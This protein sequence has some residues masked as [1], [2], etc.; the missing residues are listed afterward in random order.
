MQLAV[1]GFVAIYAP[2]LLV[3]GVDTV[4]EEEVT[5]TTLGGQDVMVTGGGG[6]GGWTTWT[7]IALAPVAVALAWWWA[8]RAVGPLDR[9]R[10]VAE[11]IEGSDL[12]RRIDLPRGPT[13]VVALA[14]GFDA[15]L[16]RL[17][18]AVTTQGALIEEASHELRTPLA[19]VLTSAD[20]ALSHPGPTL[21]EHRAALERCRAAAQRMRSTVDDLLVEARGR[22][23]SLD[24]QPVDLVALVRTVAAD[25]AVVA[26]AADVEVVVRGPGAL[27]GAVDE[28]SVR[29]A[30]AN[31]VDNAVR[32]AP[33]GST[34]EV[35]VAT[36]DGD[37]T[38]TVTDHGPGIGPE[39][40]DLV[41]E[42]FWHGPGTAAGAGL[43]LPI[44]RQVARAHGGD[45][46]LRSPSPAG[47][48]CTVTLRL[49]L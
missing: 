6:G 28:A 21:D 3:L 30:L 27:P 20:V 16:D 26:V 12:S 4:A 1:L 17:E 35:S 32:H 10:R 49:H 34:V 45:V 46:T 13:E 39:Q 7:V 5:A 41:F 24:R 44:A 47:D 38:V 14:A 42:R 9:V 40:L 11:E 25:V 31:L 15:M 33:S 19:V 29:R 2:L 43:G 48:G 18:R 36:A 37:G 8:G 23:R 22:A